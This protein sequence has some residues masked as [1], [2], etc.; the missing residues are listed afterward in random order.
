MRRTT[1]LRNIGTKPAGGSSFLH[2]EPFFG[3]MAEQGVFG[4]VGGLDSAEELGYNGGI[5]IGSFVC[6]WLKLIRI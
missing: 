5:G 2:P 6:L 4:C 3:G 1:S